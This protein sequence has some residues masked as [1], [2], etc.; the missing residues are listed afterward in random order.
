MLGAGNTILP[1]SRLIE[2]TGT[3]KS[4]SNRDHPLC[5]L[6][7][8][9]HLPMI[10]QPLVRAFGYPGE[11]TG[12]G[13]QRCAVTPPSSM[14]YRALA[15]RPNP[16]PRGSR[17][18]PLS[19]LTCMFHGSALPVSFAGTG[20]AAGH[21]DAAAIG[22]LSPCPWLK[23]RRRR[24]VPAL[25][26]DPGRCPPGHGPGRMGQKPRWRWLRGRFCG[27]AL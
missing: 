25:A 20:S 10:A 22:F 19:S 12:N 4:A 2:A 18:H 7:V 14:S 6:E 5:C 9:T 21:H 27:R 11:V 8:T 15:P 17:R 13:R 1:F 24:D 3:R 26:F 16:H 23:V